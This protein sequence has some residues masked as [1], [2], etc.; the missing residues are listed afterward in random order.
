MPPHEGEIGRGDSR[1]LAFS[2][3]IR[4]GTVWEV[5]VERVGQNGGIRDSDISGDLGRPHGIKLIRAAYS[6]GVRREL[7]WFRGGGRKETY[8]TEDYILFRM[9][10]SRRVVVT[11]A[12]NLEGPGRWLGAGHFNELSW[13]RPGLFVGTTQVGEEEC[14]VFQQFETESDGKVPRRY[15]GVDDHFP[16]FDRA[17]RGGPDTGNEGAAGID[18]PRLVQT[19]YIS[20][21]SGLPV[22]WLHGEELWRYEFLEDQASVELPPEH[23]AA[24][25]G[26]VNGATSLQQRYDYAP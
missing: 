20:K 22:A 25:E 9:P 19:A 23:A 5:R 10:G 26:H 16:E 21:V 14:Y 12:R 11:D 24:M 7:I 15:H 6:D 13:V 3:A 4:D 1:D 17:P 8:Q 2:A 18:S